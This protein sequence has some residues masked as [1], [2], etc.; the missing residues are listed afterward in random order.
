MNSRALTVDGGFVLRLS[1]SE[2]LRYQSILL[3][4]PDRL[5]VDLPGSW[6]V[7][8]PGVPKNNIATKVRVGRQADKT[9]IVI[10]LSAVPASHRVSTLNS[11]TL[12]IRIKGK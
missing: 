1:G 4:G 12:E 10:D 8:V 11:N 3:Q 9:R 5:V 2:A 6:D 7:K